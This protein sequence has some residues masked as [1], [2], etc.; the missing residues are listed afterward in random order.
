[1]KR[2]GKAKLV[3]GIVLIG[4]VTLFA[5][6]VVAARPAVLLRVVEYRTT[7]FESAEF[8][9]QSYVSAMVALTN[10]SKQTFSYISF[11]SGGPVYRVLHEASMGW[12]APETISCGF[13]LEQRSLAP[14][15]GMVFEAIIPDDKRC[16]VSFAYSDGRTP[17]A[18]WDKLPYWISARIPWATSWRTATTEVIDLRA[19]R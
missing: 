12:T 19:Q 2:V 7:R 10:R 16:K 4:A 17:S 9:K 3:A 6:L 1:M 5:L 15:E 14:A 18:Y 13:G 11:G 8:A